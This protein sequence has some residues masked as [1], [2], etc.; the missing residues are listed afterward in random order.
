MYLAMTEGLSRFLDGVDRETE[1]AF[2]E[3]IE[4]MASEYKAGLDEDPIGAMMGIHRLLDDTVAEHVVKHS[5]TRGCSHCCHLSVDIWPPEAQVIERYCKEHNI[6]IDLEYLGKQ[7]GYA[8]LELPISPVSAC[9][10]LKNGECSIYEAR[11]IMC[12]KYFVATPPEQCDHK[13]YTPQ[14]YRVTMVA[15][16][17]VELVVSAV[18]N[19]LEPKFV[20]ERMPKM[21]LKQLNVSGA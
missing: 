6:P 21:I 7:M 18:I 12:R 19:A 3:L 8:P 4:K 20:A 10:F 16:V 1:A 5:C 11:P 14:N 17:Y 13:K 2:G 9:V 15:N